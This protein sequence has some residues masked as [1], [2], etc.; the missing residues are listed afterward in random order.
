[1]HVSETFSLGESTY[2]FRWGESLAKGNLP[3]PFAE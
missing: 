3:T 2:A 1:M